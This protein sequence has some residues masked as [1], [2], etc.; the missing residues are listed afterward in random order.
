MPFQLTWLG[1]GGY[2]FELGDK[3]LCVDPYLSDAV[4]TLEGLRRMPPV[5]VSPRD[6][7]ADLVLCTHDHI[8]HLDEA[9]LGEVDDPRTRFAGPDSCLEHLRKMEFSE[10]KLVPLR[11]GETIRLGEAEISGFFADHTPDSIGVVL[12]YEGIVVYLTGDS[13]YH[14]RLTIAKT[15]RPDLLICC[16]NGQWGNMNIAEAA[17]L[18]GE[19]SVKTAVPSHYGMFAEN[20]ADPEEFRRALEGSGVN[21]KILEIGKPYPISSLLTNSVP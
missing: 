15:F 17:R 6:L 8:D 9:T 14:E 12:R 16:I 5:P 4:F 1:Q 2:L 11:Q 3:R 13:L 7:A 20:T 19:L 21:C 18:A 10:V